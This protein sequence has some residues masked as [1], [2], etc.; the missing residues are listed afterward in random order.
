MAAAKSSPTWVT[1]WRALRDL[2]RVAS[3]ALPSARAARC[4]ALPHLGEQAAA[5]EEIKT[6]ITEVPHNGPVLL[7]AARTAA[8]SGDQAAAVE[9]A[10]RALIATDPSLPPHQRKAA[11]KL[12]T[13]VTFLSGRLPGGFEHRLLPEGVDGPAEFGRIGGPH[14][15]QDQ[16]RVRHG[17]RR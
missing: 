4:L 2:D 9:L 12:A 14:V 5:E 10:E 7:Y 3:A 11:Q 6:A 17:G 13:S 16:I 15:A 1:P 8:I